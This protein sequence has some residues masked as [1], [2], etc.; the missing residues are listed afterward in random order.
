VDDVVKGVIDSVSL[1]SLYALFALGIALIFGVMRLVNFA[2]GEFIM[3]GAYGV[4]VLNPESPLVVVIVGAVATVVIFALLTERL[5]FRPVRDA[6]PATLMVT[7]FAVSFLLQNLATLIFGALPRTTN[8]SSWL[9]ESVSIAGTSVSRVSIVAVLATAL[10]VGGLALFLDRTRRGVEMRAAA[11]NFEMARLLGVRANRVIAGAFAISG[12]L[13]G[14]AS[15]L[16]I[17]QTGTAT[18]EL[19]VTP[20][21]VAFFA[22]VLGGMGS[23]RGAVLGAFILGALSTVFQMALPVELRPFRDAFVYGMV[24]ILLLARPQGL[25]VA[26]AQR[27]RV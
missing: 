6:D 24:V 4:V 27:T 9:A 16:F 19:G 26:A 8:I 21:I 15:I 5:A 17:A 20:L 18:P 23:L 10:L 7:S 12:L 2:H 22:T 11:E 13:A 14:V 3:V 1:G 25:I